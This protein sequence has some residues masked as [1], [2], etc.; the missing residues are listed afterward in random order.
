MLIRDFYS[1]PLVGSQ[2]ANAGDTGLTPGPGTKIPY[3]LR[4]L[5][6]WAT[7]AEAQ[8]LKLQQKSLHGEARA[9]HL[10]SSPTRGN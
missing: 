5:S 4:Q 6:A 3:V 8:A 7:V 9:P 2:P 10:D 1:G